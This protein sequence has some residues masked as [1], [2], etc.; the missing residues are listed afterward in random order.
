MAAVGFAPAHPQGEGQSPGLP[1][2]LKWRQGGMEEQAPGH[3]QT[4]AQGQRSPG[5]LIGGILEG[6]QGVETV[7]ASPELHQH[8]HPLRPP[9]AGQVALGWGALRCRRGG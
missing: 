4:I 9:T 5:A 7:V 1:G 2:G 6:A 3:R 8:D